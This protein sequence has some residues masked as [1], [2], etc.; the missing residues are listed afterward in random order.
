M[1]LFVLWNSKVLHRVKNP[2]IYFSQGQVN[3]D[4]LISLFL[5]FILPLPVHVI[6]VT[7]LNMK[8]LLTLITQMPIPQRS[9]RS[10]NSIFSTVQ[11]YCV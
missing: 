3:S 1:L 10:Q 2:I 11:A 6:M 4:T 5:I 7:N 8:V 9:G